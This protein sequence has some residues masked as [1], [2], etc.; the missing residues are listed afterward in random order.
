MSRT[1]LKPLLRMWASAL[2]F[3]DSLARRNRQ[4]PIA[5]LVYVAFTSLCVSN[6]LLLWHQTRSQRSAKGRFQ[7]RGKQSV[8][9]PGQKKD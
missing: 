7:R 4:C 3:C 6:Y 1:L 9:C 5:E 2:C 8:P